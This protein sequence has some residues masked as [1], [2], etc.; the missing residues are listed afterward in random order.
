MP[1][2]EKTSIVTDDGLGKDGLIHTKFLRNRSFA[3]SG[4][5]ANF[6]S[7][8]RRLCLFAWSWI[9]Q[10]RWV[11]AGSFAMHSQLQNR[12]YSYRSL[13]ELHPMGKE[14]TSLRSLHIS[15]F[16]PMSYL[17]RSLDSS[18]Y[19]LTLLLLLHSHR[20]AWYLAGERERP[21]NAYVSMKLT[22]DPARESKDTGEKNRG[23]RD[24]EKK[25]NADCAEKKKTSVKRKGSPYER[26]K[27]KGRKEQGKNTEATS[28]GAGVRIAEKKRRGSRFSQSPIRENRSNRNLERNAISRDLDSR[29]ARCS[30]TQRDRQRNPHQHL[31]FDLMP[32]AHYPFIMR[33]DLSS[34][35]RAPSINRDT[36]MGSLAV[37]CTG[38][39]YACD[40]YPREYRLRVLDPSRLRKTAVDEV[41]LLRRAHLASDFAPRNLVADACTLLCLVIKVSL[42]AR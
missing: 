19:V 13:G 3:L 32:D 17:N 21:P 39:R 1:F 8:W 24:Q 6:R 42:R 28:C 4:F 18:E 22:F 10:S 2:R 12:R 35:S 23:R 5:D 29:C 33:A 20:I 31:R 38:E 14:R 40:R 34:L 27:K 36:C 30:L 15:R 9:F 25:E 7:R 41:T 37:K 26:R 16:N 11:I